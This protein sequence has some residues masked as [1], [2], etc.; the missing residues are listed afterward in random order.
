MYCS[1]SDFNSLNSYAPYPLY[2]TPKYHNIYLVH[3][4][5]MLIFFSETHNYLNYSN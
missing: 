4:I 3:K 2:K 1:I 5:F